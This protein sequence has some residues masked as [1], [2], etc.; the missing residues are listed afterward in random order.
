MISMWNGRAGGQETEGVERVFSQ[1]Q[2]NYD[3]FTAS[4]GACLRAYS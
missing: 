1:I 4:I 2:C 3:I